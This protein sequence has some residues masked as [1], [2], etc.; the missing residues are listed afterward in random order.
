VSSSNLDAYVTAWLKHH[1]AAVNEPDMQEILA[2]FSDDVVYEDVPTGS[3][4][5]GHDAFRQM[6]GIVASYGLD[7]TLNVV[8]TQTDGKSFAI[9]WT[10]VTKLPDG[11]AIPGR[12][13]SVG[14]FDGQGKV[15]SHRDYYD[16]SNFPAPSH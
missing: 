1:H 7:I 2:L 9:E 11:T 16:R 6:C 5:K 3:E 15:S 14:M 4:F 13:V 10:N 12:G 8:Q